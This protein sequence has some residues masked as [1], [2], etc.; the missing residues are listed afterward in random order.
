M[1]AKYRADHIGSLL[2]PAELLQARSTHTD[3]AQ[4]RALE[5]KHILRVIERQKEL[6]F[7]IFTDGELRR[8]NFMSDFNDAVEGIDDGVAVARTWQTGA[9]VSPRPSMVPG[10]ALG[11]IKQTR[12]LTVHE[13]AFFKQHSPGD[14]KVTL[15]T[16]NQFPA[17]YYK[18]GISDKIYPAYSDF[19]WDIVPIIKD[20]VHAL[21]GEGAQYVQI[22]APR[23]SYY[24]DPK[25]RGYIKREMGLD[26]EQALEE[27]IRAD[28]ACLEGVKRAG[29]TLA[30]HLCRGNNRSQWY[31]EGGYDAIAEKLFGQ[32][33]VDAFLLEY[34][35]ERAGTFEPLRFVPR[36][37]TV[38]LGL[39]SSKLPE[40]ESQD[41]LAKRIDEASK[42]VPLEN[43]AISPQCGFASTMEGNLLTEDQQWQKLKLVV[44]TAHKVW[45]RA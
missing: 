9:G 40:L 14:V 37:K 31:A 19:L 21:V 29:V 6:G 15:P 36:A 23:Y 13:F 39:V 5:D 32:L 42:Y 17:I 25:W 45:E 35:S 38:V 10:T 18:K 7:K 8:S 34:E 20:E 30:I 26:P 27:A 28:N 12:R 41:Y 16:A 43:L 1:P 2:R 22:D 11:K 33:N 24:I 3:T 4:L 44:D